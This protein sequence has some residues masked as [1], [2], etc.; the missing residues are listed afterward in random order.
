MLNRDEILELIKEKDMIIGYIDL[1]VQL[2]PNG[3][4]LTVEEIYDFHPVELGVIQFKD[5]S[6]PDKLMTIRFGPLPKLMTIMFGPL[7]KSTKLNKG[8]YKFKINETIKL[9]DDIVAI[10][11]QRSTVMRCGCMCNVGYWDCGYHGSGYSIINVMHPVEIHRNARLIQM[12][13]YKI[14]APSKTYNGS[15]QKENVN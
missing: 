4:D 15:Y 8:V 10:T 12:Y 3:F 7:Y 13:F 5:K 14:N 6:I 11:T 1:D 9:P 2:Q